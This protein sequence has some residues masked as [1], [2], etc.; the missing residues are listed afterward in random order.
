VCVRAR[1]ALLR[2]VRERFGDERRRHDWRE[3]TFV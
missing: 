2:D 1:R 3:V